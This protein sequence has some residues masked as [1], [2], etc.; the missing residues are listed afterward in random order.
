MEKLTIL[1]LVSS[2]LPH[3][4]ISVYNIKPYYYAYNPTYD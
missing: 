3:A 4:K 1:E 2:L